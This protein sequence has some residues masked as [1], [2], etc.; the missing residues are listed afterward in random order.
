MEQPV[1]SFTAED[2]AKAIADA[3]TLP[4]YRM[5]PPP[6]DADEWRAVAQIDSND[7]LLV[8]SAAEALHFGLA[9][10]TIAT[11][12]ELKAFFG[13]TTLTRFHQNWSESL[14]RVL[15]NFWVRIVLI[16]VFL[17]C[18]FVEMAAPGFGIFG[19]TSLI[20]L[21]LLI[22]APLLVGMAQ[23][24]DVLL[25]VVGIGLVGVELFILPGFGVAGIGGAVCLLVGMV[26]TFV[27]G[28]VSTPQGQNEI[29]GGLLATLTG[30]FGGAIGIWIASRYVRTFPLFQ[31]LVLSSELRATTVSTRR[32]RSQGLIEAMGPQ[33]TGATLQKG[34]EG[35]AHTDLRPAGRAM[36]DGRVVDVQ[37]DGTYIA[38][39]ARIRVVSV[40][41]YVIDVEEVES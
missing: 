23:W 1:E 7:R 4:S 27:S 39:G 34:A 36:F 17:V 5:L 30:V 13:A 6:E 18:L 15:T 14:V 37:S 35:V 38:K 2:Q 12:D 26:G 11:D 8:V 29:V 41:R 16:V 31:R 10:R 21:L 28:D 3:Q 9:Q 40:G 25:I 32:T 22:G 19:V 33:R 20:A 24:W